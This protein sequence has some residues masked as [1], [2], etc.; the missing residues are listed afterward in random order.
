MM[1]IIGQM[2]AGAVCAWATGAGGQVLA[3]DQ[4]AG[5][6]LLWLAGALLECVL[7]GLN[8][9]GWAPFA[10]PGRPLPETLMTQ[11]MLVM[12]VLHLGRA[13]YLLVG[14]NLQLLVMTLALCTTTSLAVHKQ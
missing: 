3:F 7:R 12:F 8:V 5:L 13:S 4:M 14:L 10:A 2:T 11:A 9:Y 6:L 1:A